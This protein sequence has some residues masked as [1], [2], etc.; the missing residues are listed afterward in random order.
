[1]QPTNQNFLQN[2]KWQFSIKR[3][4]GISFFVQ[5][6]NIPSITGVRRDVPTPFVKYPVPYDHLDYGEL[7][8]SFK[9]NEDMSNYLEV[10]NWMVGLG[11]PDNFGQHRALVNVPPA[12]DKEYSDATLLVLTNA[13]NAGLKVE[14]QRCFPVFLSDIEFDTGGSGNEIDCTVTFAYEKFTVTPIS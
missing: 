10:Y 6:V 11:F 9:I 1:M 4:P 5:S 3:L 13:K 8:V 2:V 14:Y 12:Q 7:N